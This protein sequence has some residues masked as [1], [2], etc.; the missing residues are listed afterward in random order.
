[1]INARGSRT[2]NQSN[3]TLH[4]ESIDVSVSYNEQAYIWD[5]ISVSQVGEQEAIYVRYSNLFVGLKIQSQNGNQSLLFLQVYD[6]EN[7]RKYTII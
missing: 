4:A 2:R 6:A 1:M 3:V 7:K 5:S